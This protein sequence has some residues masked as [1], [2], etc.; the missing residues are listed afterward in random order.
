MQLKASALQTHPFKGPTDH[1]IQ[2]T[3]PTTHIVGTYQISQ[4]TL[5]VNLRLKIGGGERQKMGRHKAENK[6]ISISQ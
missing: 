2:D 4:Y 3:G 6:I 5:S 1:S